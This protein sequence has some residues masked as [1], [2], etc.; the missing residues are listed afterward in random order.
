MTSPVRG[1]V[2]DVQRF[3]VHDGPGIRTTVFLSGCSLRCAWCHNPESFSGDAGFWREPGEVLAQ[4]LRDREYFETSGG[5]LTVSGGEPL[6]QPAFV[7]EL[8]G[9]AMAEGLHTCLQ[10]AGEVSREA[11]AGVLEV[12]DLFQFDVKHLDPARHEA[13]TGRRNERLLANLEWLLGQGRAVE[14]R[15]PLVPGY[16]DAPEHLERVGAFLR[17][18][19]VGALHVL[20]YQRT[21]L[22]KYERLGLAARCAEVVPPASSHLAAVRTLLGARGIDLLVDA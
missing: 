19:G 18:R 17:A 21:Y 9:R 22:P 6:L 15:L 14:V 7:R 10:T 20:P 4:V 12:V 5:G 8:L 16:N 1:R 11:L 2:F 13:L 3:C